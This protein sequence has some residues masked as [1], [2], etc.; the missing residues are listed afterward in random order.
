[1]LMLKAF[2]LMF[3]V[4]FFLFFKKRKN[5]TAHDNN[6]SYS[7]EFRVEPS[8]YNYREINKEIK[9]IFHNHPD[10]IA[11]LV[12]VAKAD[13]RMMQKELDVV[14]EIIAGLSSGITIPIHFLYDDI[15]EIPKINPD[16]FEGYLERI[17]AGGKAEIGLF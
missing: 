9:K 5:P 7:N 2:I 17:A 3:V 6:L 8:Q 10:L 1:M 16:E 14:T 11:S 12:F 13:G 15:K 4:A